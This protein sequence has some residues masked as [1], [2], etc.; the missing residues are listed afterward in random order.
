MWQRR[1]PWSQC[2][3]S[4]NEA[5]RGLERGRLF[6]R[7]TG[8]HRVRVVGQFLTLVDPRWQLPARTIAV[9]ARVLLCAKVSSAPPRLALPPSWQ[10]GGPQLDVDPRGTSL[11]RREDGERLATAKRAPTCSC[12]RARYRM[13]AGRCAAG[14]CSRKPPR[15]GPCSYRRSGGR[16]LL[17]REGRPARRSGPPHRRAHPEWDED[18]PAIEAIS[19]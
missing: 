13:T 11:L 7:N 5:H 1:G 15:V 16:S 3:C 6:V 18:D 19:T 2:C 12:A 10:R 4:L 9:A 17:V 14:A 8:C